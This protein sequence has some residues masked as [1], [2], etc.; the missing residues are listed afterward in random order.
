MLL[1]LLLNNLLS[2]TVTVNIY[3]TAEGSSTAAAAFNGDIYIAG[4]SDGTCDVDAILQRTTLAGVSVARVQ[5]PGPLREFYLRDNR[6]SQLQGPYTYYEAETKARMATSIAARTGVGDPVMEMVTIL[7]SRQG[8]PPQP[9]NQIKVVAVYTKGR[10][11]IGGAIAQ[12]N[13]NR[14]NT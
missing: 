7:G 3:G 4:I 14:G 9:S 2:G 13:S 5:T 11:T 8:D 12:Y 10:K 1:P 6:F